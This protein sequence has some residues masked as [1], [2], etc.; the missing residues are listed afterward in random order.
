[1]AVDL[2]HVLTGEAA[3]PAHQQQQTSSRRRPRYRS[4]GR[5]P[6]GAIPHSAV[7][8]MHNARP[9]F[10]AGPERRITAMPPWPG[11]TAAT[12]ARVGAGHSI[13][14]EIHTGD[15]AA[16][17][18]IH[19]PV[20][21]LQSPPRV[22]RG[23]LAVNR[24]EPQA[25]GPAAC[26]WRVLRLLSSSAADLP[27]RGCGQRARQPPPAAAGTLVSNPHPFPL[28]WFNHRKYVYPGQGDQPSRANVQP[29]REGELSRIQQRSTI[30]G[31]VLAIAS[32]WMLRNLPKKL[33]RKSLRKREFQK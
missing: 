15:P 14:V 4:R 29:Y 3:G 9:C 22:P 1:M 10:R 27:Q 5:T 6:P 2:H 26:R 18:R 17:S 19:A 32:G 11:A 20:A 24:R 12:A 23:S 31:M 16:F 7:P 28:Y 25:N 30:T 8:G 21:A 13:G 33:K